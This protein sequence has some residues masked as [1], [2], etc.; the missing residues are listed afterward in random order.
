MAENTENTQSTTES[1]FQKKSGEHVDPILAHLQTGD[2]EIDKGK[3]REHFIQLWEYEDGENLSAEDQYLTT[4]ALF[5]YTSHSHLDDESI[6]QNKAREYIVQALH[7]WMAPELEKMIA[8]EKASDNPFKAFVDGNVPLVDERYSWK[9]FMLEHKKTGEKEWTY[10]MKKCWFAQF[11]IRFG[12]VDYIQTACLFDKIPVDARA[13]YVNLQLQ[14]LF[15]K[16]GQLCQFKYT[17]AKKE[18]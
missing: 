16:L 9:N 17:P 11:F 3:I 6:R 8:A 13:D 1:E 15:A 7:T 14:N 4:V 2:H 12:R 5:I 10:K 18:P